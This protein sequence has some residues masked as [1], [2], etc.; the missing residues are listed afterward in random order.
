MWIDTVGTFWI[1][2]IQRKKARV[3]QTFIICKFCLYNA[4]SSGFANCRIMVNFCST[5]H[6][7]PLLPF[8]SPSQI[9]H[10][11]SDFKYWCGYLSLVPRDQVCLY[12]YLLS[13]VPLV[14]AITSPW[15][16]G[17]PCACSYNSL[18]SSGSSLSC[19]SSTSVC[20]LLWVFPVDWLCDVSGD[21]FALTEIQTFLNIWDNGNEM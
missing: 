14:C 8:L 2:I 1:D 7:L 3:L 4:P 17:N 21:T 18:V 16:H 5:T 19:S 20:F 13:L 6:S 9:P 15:Y 12:M 10:I 11:R